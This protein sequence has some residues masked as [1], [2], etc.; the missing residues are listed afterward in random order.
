MRVA[1]SGISVNRRDT[2]IKS[3]LMSKAK[4]K[5]DYCYAGTELQDLEITCQH[6]E[7][8]E[9]GSSQSPGLNTGF[10]CHKGDC[11]DT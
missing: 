9:S 5:K 7:K 2:V 1:G 11:R 4:K 8:R 10:L 3:L 6:C